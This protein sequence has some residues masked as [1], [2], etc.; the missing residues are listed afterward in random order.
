MRKVSKEE[1]ERIITNALDML[2]APSAVL[3]T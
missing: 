2:V 1:I 3:T